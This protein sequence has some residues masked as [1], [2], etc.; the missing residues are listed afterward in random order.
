MKKQIVP[1]VAALV[2]AG[3][4]AAFA[5]IPGSD[6]VIHACFRVSDGQLRVVDPA[7]EGSCAHGESALSWN[8]QGRPGPRGPKGAVGPRGPKGLMGHR[9]LK[10]VAGRRGPKGLK[11][12]P[13]TPGA[14]GAPGGPGDPGITV[15]RVVASLDPSTDPSSV[16]SWTQPAGTIANV[17]WRVN[18]TTPGGSCLSTVAEHVGQFQFWLNDTTDL[19]QD[20]SSADMGPGQTQSFPAIGSDSTTGTTGA[21]FPGSYQLKTEF[22][23]PAGSVPASDCIGTVV[24]TEVFVETELTP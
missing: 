4:V 13:G 16:A 1:M 6:G 23:T 8:A 21:L 5:S 9:G 2:L 20:Q 17:Y 7:H 24:Q 12:G 18:V 11:G 15:T 14:P 10:G 22:V 19:G 3:S